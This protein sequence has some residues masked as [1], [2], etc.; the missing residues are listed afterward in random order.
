MGESAYMNSKSYLNKSGVICAV[1]AFFMNLLSS[2]QALAAVNYRDLGVEQR[3]A[4]I[5][6]IVQ[7]KIVPK[8][9]DMY[10][11]EKKLLTEQLAIIT[12]EEDTRYSIVPGDTMEISYKDQGQVMKNIYKVNDEGQIVMPLIGAVK[13]LGMNRGQARAYLT[14]QIGEYI[15]RPELVVELNTKGDYIVIGAASAG[16]YEIQ[17]N[18]NV[19]E[20]ILKAGYQS[21]QANL[22]NV[23]VMRGG[24]SNPTTLKLNLKK[25]I[26]KGDRS[27]NIPVKPGDLIYVPNTFFY[28]FEQFKVKIFDY[29][30]DYYTLGG[31]TILEQKVNDPTQQDD[32]E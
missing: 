32:A 11:T 5:K 7:D 10:E 23:I 29:I 19:M 6:K 21:N 18:L 28:D 12:G 25:M 15:R 8:S 24:R 22:G 30:L 27:D 14:A 3:R 20:A 13:V 17:P 4:E 9:D 2:T 1:I 16:V 26:R 31:S